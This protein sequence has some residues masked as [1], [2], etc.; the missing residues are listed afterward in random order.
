MVEQTFE[1]GRMF[2]RGDEATS[3]ALP[4]GQPFGA[5]AD[6][7]EESQPLYSCPDLAPSQTPP[8][9]QRGFGKGWRLEAGVRQGLG[10]ATG[11]ERAFRAT[12]QPF[13]SGLIFQTDAGVWYVLER[14]SNSWERVE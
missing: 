9:P 8:P 6:T 14:R 11:Q 1:E 10:N 5:F 12:A 2:W 4:D 13:D 7:W 3:Y